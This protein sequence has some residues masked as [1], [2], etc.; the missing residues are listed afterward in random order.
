M[1]I[2]LSITG[3]I[4]ILS[5]TAIILFIFLKG[6][7]STFPAISQHAANQTLIDIKSIPKDRYLHAKVVVN[8]YEM[9]V[10]LAI[11]QYQR[12]QGLA[13]KN[14]LNEN[15]GM[16]F[17]FEQPSRQGFWMKGMKFPID[18]IWLDNNDTVVHIEQNLQPCASILSCPVYTPHSDSLNVLETVAGFSQKHGVKIGTHLDF[19]LTSTT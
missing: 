1:I 14:H 16:L 19:N 4:I 13:V 6:N 10:D 11:T 2:K 8:G 5:A 12:E 7:F 9:S 15:E 17:V 18:I 3:K